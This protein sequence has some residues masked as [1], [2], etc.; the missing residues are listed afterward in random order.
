ME[1][2]DHSEAST[3]DIHKNSTQTTSF[4]PS[5]DSFSRFCTHCNSTIHTVDVFW[6]KH[7]YP[8]WYKLKQVERK[9]KKSAPVAITDATPPASYSQVSRLSS[10]EDN[11]G[12]A[13]ISIAS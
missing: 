2:K 3:M 6:K 13:L 12:L 9:N 11:S 1:T 7:S 10:L 8:K 4:T 5:T